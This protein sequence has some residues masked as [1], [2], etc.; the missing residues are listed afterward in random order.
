VPDST[1]TTTEPDAAEE[2]E[3][4]ELEL[5][6]RPWRAGDVIDAPLLLAR[7]HVRPEWIDANG[8]MGMSSYAHAMMLAGKHWLEYLGL[9]YVN[10]GNTGRS[11]FALQWQMNLKRELHKG[12][13]IAFHCR[14]LDWGHKAFHYF[15]TL[16]NETEG[17]TAATSEHLDIHIDMATR[18][19]APMPP[20]LRAH[21]EAL[22]AAHGDL[23][24]PEEAGKG[25][26]VR[27]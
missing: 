7:G 14:L 17:Y 10:V 6:A 16:E 13:R 24:W 26:A 22:T 18:R 21:M 9:G 3:E 8:H 1:P 25:I 23:P 5:M 19:T 27:R 2:A 12:A 4:S 15:V 20:A 11:S